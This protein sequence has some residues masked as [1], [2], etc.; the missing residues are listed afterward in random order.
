ME[1]DVSGATSFSDIDLDAPQSQYGTYLDQL[2]PYAMAW[3]MSWGEFWYESLDRLHDYWQA[4]QYSIERRNQEL[5]VQG[6]YIMEAVAV[7]FDPKHKAKYPDKP[8]RIT[9]M[10]DAE[11]E[12]ENKRKVERLREILN[13]HKQEFDKRNK[14]KGVGLI[15]R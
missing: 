2:C 10:T 13:I 9:E 5:W 8:Y 14:D 4:N 12:A 11:R 1:T 15:D 3:G 7:V 6:M